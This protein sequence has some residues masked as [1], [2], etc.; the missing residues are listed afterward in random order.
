MSCAAC[1]Q[2]LE[3]AQRR[4]DAVSLR[5]LLKHGLHQV[6]PTTAG[7]QGIEEACTCGGQASQG[8][9]GLQAKTAAWTLCSRQPEDLTLPESSGGYDRA[10]PPILMLSWVCTLFGYS[11]HTLKMLCAQ[12]CCA[13]RRAYEP[14]TVYTKILTCSACAGWEARVTRLATTPGRPTHS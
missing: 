3:Q 12:Q 14:M 11:R 1:H 8:R 2:H 9:D 7:V 6:L 5:R 4:L 10:S 13:W